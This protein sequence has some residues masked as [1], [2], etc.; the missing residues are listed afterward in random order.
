MK[1]FHPSVP[2]NEPLTPFPP[3]LTIGERPRILF[4]ERHACT[5]RTGHTDAELVGVSMNRH[6]QDILGSDLVGPMGVPR[7]IRPVSGKV[8]EALSEL[9]EISQSRQDPSMSS[10]RNRC[11]A[12]STLLTG[13]YAGQT[14]L[15]VLTPTVCPFLAFRDGSNP[16]P[17]ELAV[18][19]PAV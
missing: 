6:L 7:L 12:R 5:H 8:V 3:L 11:A 18:Q 14:S 17:L 2:T 15:V 4:F 9:N 16:W 19:S 13:R 1:Y 10:A